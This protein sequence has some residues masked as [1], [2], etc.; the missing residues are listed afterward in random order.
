MLDAEIRITSDKL[1]AFEQCFVICKN[2]SG[3]A[4]SV[5]DAL[6]ELNCYILGYI[7]CW[8]GFH[9]FGERV[10]FDVQICETSWC[11]GQD[12]HD[13]D[14]PDYKRPRDINRPKMIGMLHH[15]FL[16]ELAISAFL[17][18]FHCIIL[19]GGPIKSMPKHFTNDRAL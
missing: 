6:Q 1:C 2:S 9:A 8:H 13:V 18:D 12:A 19:R 17:Y 15:L 7:H 11:P 16:E 10:N 5:Y 4:K 3:H 14:S